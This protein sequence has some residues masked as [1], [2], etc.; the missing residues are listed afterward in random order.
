MCVCV[1][2]SDQ[3]IEADLD[4]TDAIVNM[5]LPTDISS[6]KQNSKMIN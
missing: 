6:S 3:G 4:N 5:S 1:C 2:V